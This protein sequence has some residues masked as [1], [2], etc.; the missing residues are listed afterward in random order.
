MT[1]VFGT[2]TLR[3]NLWCWSLNDCEADDERLS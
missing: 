3:R 1:A 2:V